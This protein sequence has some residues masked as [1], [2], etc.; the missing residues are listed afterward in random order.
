MWTKWGLGF[1]NFYERTVNTREKL[2]KQKIVSIYFIEKLLLIIYFI[3]F[4]FD[5]QMSPK[6]EREKIQFLKNSTN[7]RINITCQG[8]TVE[9]GSWKFGWNSFRLWLTWPSSFRSSIK[10]VISTSSFH[11]MLYW[12]NLGFN[13]VRIVKR[14][15]NNLLIARI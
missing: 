12:G 3:I 11:Y 1:L 2:W 13:S 7:R 8:V 4:E 6:H 5:C 15:E 10:K 9:D 14:I